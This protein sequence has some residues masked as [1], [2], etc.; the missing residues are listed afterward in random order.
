MGKMM[1]RPVKL[2]EEMGTARGITMSSWWRACS[3]ETGRCQHVLKVAKVT[4]GSGQVEQVESFSCLAR[5][6]GYILVSTSQ[7]CWGTTVALP[8]QG[9]NQTLTLSVTL[10]WLISPTTFSR[11]SR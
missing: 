5:T 9:V 11:K 2:R 10:S 7:Q 6:P 3:T 1:T 8:E 4:R